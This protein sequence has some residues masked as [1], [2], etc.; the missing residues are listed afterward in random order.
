MNL[1]IQSIIRL[2]QVTKTKTTFNVIVN[3]CVCTLMGLVFIVYNNQV[4]KYLNKKPF[5]LPD[6]DVSHKTAQ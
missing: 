3:E 4:I 2:F 5:E 1:E 6:D